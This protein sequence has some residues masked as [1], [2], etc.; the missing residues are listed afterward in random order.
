[1]KDKTIL[2]ISKSELWH[3]ASRPNVKRKKEYLINIFLK[4]SSFGSRMKF[5]EKE[6]LRYCSLL[7]KAFGD[8]KDGSYYSG[9]MYSGRN[10]PHLLTTIDDRGQKGNGFVVVGINRDVHH[11]QKRLVIKTERSC[12][13]SVQVTLSGDEF[14]NF[15]SACLDLAKKLKHT[16]LRDIE[17]CPVSSSHIL[18]AHL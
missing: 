14:L 9:I 2:I 6:F 4:S 13:P 8:L 15:R 16:R 1:M 11:F 5:S 3:P 7:S 18:Q 10:K 17:N 12:A